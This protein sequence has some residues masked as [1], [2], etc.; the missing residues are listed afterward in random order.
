ME[1]IERR[2]REISLNCDQTQKV[3]IASNQ[4][5]IFFY[6][7][8]SYLSNFYEASITI[9]GDIHF[10]T[11]EHYFQYLKAKFF[12]DIERMKA[13][14]KCQ[15]PREAKRLG[16][17]VRG[18]LAAKWDP[19]SIFAMK[20]VLEAKF[21]QNPKLAIKL[22]VTRDAILVEASPYDRK[23]GIGLDMSHP[24]ITNPLNWK[25]QNRLGQLLMTVRT[26]MQQANDIRHKK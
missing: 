13:I 5:Y 23:W 20:T 1:D 18:F 24:G 8:R 14:A 26:E 3:D 9:H 21:E 11:S 6:Q 25:G 16:S 15:A 19:E 4:C 2:F 12:G 17:M 22:L 7:S 10:P